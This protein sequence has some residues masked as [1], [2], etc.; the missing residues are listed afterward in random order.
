MAKDLQKSTVERRRLFGCK[1]GVAAGELQDGKNPKHAI[2]QVIDGGV[3]E[4]ALQILLRKGSVGGEDDGGHCKPQQRRS[5]R[6]QLDTKDGEQ[7]PQEA[8][9]THLRHN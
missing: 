9:Q 3:S 5:N 2:A 1:R 7:Y 8:I 4:D 6:S